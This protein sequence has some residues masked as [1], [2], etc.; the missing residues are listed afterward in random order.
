MDLL[1]LK[2]YDKDLVS[3]KDKYFP[4]SKSHCRELPLFL[5][6]EPN[7]RWLIFVT[8]LLNL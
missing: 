1:Q 5:D 4:I 8:F 3:I 2:G 6:F 7:Y